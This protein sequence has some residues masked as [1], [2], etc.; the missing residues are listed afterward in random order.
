MIDN[1]LV[2]TQV[3]VTSGMLDASGPGLTR[4]ASLKRDTGP[5]DGRQTITRIGGTAPANVRA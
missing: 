1:S 4:R 2:A 3:R 5:P